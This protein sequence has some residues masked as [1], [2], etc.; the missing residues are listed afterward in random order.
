M[1]INLQGWYVYNMFK[2]S[3]NHLTLDMI[4]RIINQTI[5]VYLNVYLIRQLPNNIKAS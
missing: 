4:K 5:C 1:F 2:C 3:L